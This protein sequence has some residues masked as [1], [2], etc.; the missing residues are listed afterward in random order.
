MMNSRNFLLTIL[1][2]TFHLSPLFSQEKNY[3]LVV[4]GGTASGVMAA[5]AAGKEGMKAALLV[6][7]KHVGGLTA[8]GLGWVDV[9]MTQAIGGYTLDFF[10]RVSKSYR[11]PQPLFKLT[12]SVA[13]KIF[14]QMAKEAGVAIF[15]DARLIEKKGVVLNGKKIEKLLLENKMQ[16]KAPVFIDATYEGDLMAW[17]NV[18]YTVGRESRSQYGESEAGR[19]T[20][21][22]QPVQLSAG[23]VAEIKELAKQFPLDYHF[24][25]AIPEGAG[26][27]KIQAYTFRL[28]LTTKAGN[29]VPFRKPAKYNPRRYA[30]LLNDIITRQIT[31]FD[32]VCTV[33]L[34]PDEKTDINHLDLDNASHNYPDGSYAQ[35]NYLWQYHKDYEEGLLYFVANDPQ[36]PEA[37][38]KDAQRYGFAK[39]E[40]TDNNNWPYLLYAREG[41]RMTGAYVMKQ[42]DS[43]EHVKKE[44]VIGMGSY[45]LDSH[46]VQKTITADHHQFVE[47]GFRHIPYKPYQVPYRSLTPMQRDC[48]NLY[49]TICLSASHVI[50]G[51][52]RMEPI[53][54]VIGHAA[55]TAATMAVKNKVAVQQVN[56]KTLQQKLLQQGQVFDF[57]LE[58]DSYLEKH[59]FSGIIIDDFEAAV[60]GKW[61]WGRS[62]RSL[63][64][65]MGGYQT[66][67]QSPRETASHTY[68]PQIPE[69][70]NY[71]VY[72][73]YVADK[74][75]ARDVR[76]ILNTA[77]GEKI[78]TVDMS[79]KPAD[80]YWLSLGKFR[81][82]KGNEGK[83]K[84]SNEG[85]YGGIVCA[86]AV[87]FVRL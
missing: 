17:A 45:F 15:Y 64:F 85:S 26:D 44:D 56:I 34:L 66:V 60:T 58:A 87:R 14:L 81:F 30:T 20:R 13:E 22:Y 52:L 55:G 41:R 12:P 49:V 75:K 5:Y 83:V 80:G 69:S 65:L 16:F 71:E 50:Y 67:A 32:K 36:V 21:G 51:S 39:D 54:M 78:I 48:E 2:M 82:N 40:F 46:D 3:D 10:K 35:R 86:D 79:Q 59:T 62:Q 18:P 8:S 38:R 1:L 57:P 53:F 23:R 27:D 61:V 29:K 25:E 28:T 31:R 11:T 42:Q 77:D 6:Q 37:L 74:N 24:G 47:G 63:P 19:G 33:N 43:W 9:D 7:G 76:I 72:V 4:Y 68:T 70:G 73:M 84:I